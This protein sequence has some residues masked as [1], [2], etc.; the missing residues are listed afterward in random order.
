M[1]KHEGPSGETTRTVEIRGVEHQMEYDEMDDPPSG[2]DG[3]DDFARRRSEGDGD[4]DDDEKRGRRWSKTVG[5]W[6]KGTKKLFGLKEAEDGYSEGA[7]LKKS[8]ST[9]GFIG[10]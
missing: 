1:W 4:E 5:S 9:G 3:E 6:G 10:S 2:E 8:V 7:P